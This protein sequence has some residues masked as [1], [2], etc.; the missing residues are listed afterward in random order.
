MIFGRIIKGIGGLYFVDTDNDIYECSVRGIFRKN[1]IVP[2][3]GDFVDINVIDEKKLKA[4]IETIHER[5][6]IMVRPKVSN[7]DCAVITFA[8]K[9]PNINYN[10]IDRFLILAQYY[11]IENIVICIN[12]CDL[13]DEED[14]NYI[15]RIYEPL[16]NVI[17]TSTLKDYGIDEIKNVIK[18]KVSVLAGPSGVGKSSLINCIIPKSSLKTGEISFKIERGKHTT[19]QVEL[20][21]VSENT[22]IMDSPGFTSLNLSEIKPEKLQNY[23]KEFKPYLN[24]CRFNDCMH[25]NEPDCIIT[26]NLGKNIA[27]ERYDR[28]VFLFNELKQ[29]R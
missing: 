15:K 9:K 22:Y 10:L 28:Y 21:K 27:K 23:F 1:K 16:Y 7:I 19:R 26:Q 17:Y 4:S 20:I 5:K 2:T 29:R 25:I 6:N 11:N 8:I 24:K 18:N 12:K 13:S 3:V 14:I